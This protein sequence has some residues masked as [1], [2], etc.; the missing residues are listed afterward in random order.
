[1]M[2]VPLLRSF[3]ASAELQAQ[4]WIADSDTWLP[5]KSDVSL[6]VQSGLSKTQ[7]F[8]VSYRSLV[9]S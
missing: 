8:C 4:D 9:L 7:L 2:K 6:Q 3:A 1:M 5:F